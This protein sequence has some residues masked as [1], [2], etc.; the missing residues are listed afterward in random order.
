MVRDETELSPTERRPVALW[1]CG[2]GVTVKEGRV[3]TV[4]YPPDYNRAGRG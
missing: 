2:C 1:V 4:R 3:R